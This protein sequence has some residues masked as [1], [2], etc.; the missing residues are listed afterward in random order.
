VSTAPTTH[1][2][3]NGGLQTLAISIA[4]VIENVGR[5]YSG[6]DDATALDYI[7]EAFRKAC[8]WWPLEVVERDIELTAEQ[9]KYALAAGEMRVIYCHYYFDSG[10]P[11]ILQAGSVTEW[12]RE[13]GSWRTQRSSTPAEYAVEAGNIV[14][15]PTPATSSVGTGSNAYPR[16]RI[17]AWKYT[18]RTS[19]GDLPE[20]IDEHNWFSAYAKKRYASDRHPRDLQ[21]REFEEREAFLSL[22]MRL[23]ERAKDNRPQLLPMPSGLH[24]E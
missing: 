11:R 10:T 17:E 12:D 2:N 8:Y 4:E 9:K 6:I 7:N 21:M 24:M 13:M 20:I 23:G 16:I 18:A 1:E 22:Q 19:G 5:A 14:L 3:L 15:R